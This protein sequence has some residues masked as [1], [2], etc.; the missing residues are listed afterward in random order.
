MDLTGMKYGFLAN[1]RCEESFFSKNRRLTTPL[2]FEPKFDIFFKT[3]KI[4]YITQKHLTQTEYVP[5][6]DV[7]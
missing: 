6:M 3:P 5:H 7:I 4:L 2:G 1:F